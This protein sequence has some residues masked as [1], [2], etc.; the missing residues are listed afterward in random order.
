MK[1]HPVHAHP[2]LPCPPLS[3]CSLD[4]STVFPQSVNVAI[5][6]QF[7][8]SSSCGA[9]PASVHKLSTLNLTCSEHSLLLLTSDCGGLGQEAPS[10]EQRT[11]NDDPLH[12]TAPSDADV[13]PFPF[14]CTKL[15]G[16]TFPPQ[17]LWWCVLCPM[18]ALALWGVCQLTK[19]VVRPAKRR[20]VRKFLVIVGL[21]LG[22]GLGLG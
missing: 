22:L 15:R 19:R 4:T 21:G 9:L 11:Q 5:M 20:S 17:V 2:P 1:D 10:P 7:L 12:G 13:R 3:L 6:Q 14:L 16:N 18:L 8:H